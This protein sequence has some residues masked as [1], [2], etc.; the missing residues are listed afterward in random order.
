MAISSGS[1]AAR[2]SGT[3]SGLFPTDWTLSWANADAGGQAAKRQR[4]VVAR[5]LLTYASVLV[6]D[7][8]T[9][10]LD[11]TTASELVDEVLSATGGPNDA[12][13][14]SSNEGLNIVDRIVSL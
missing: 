10:H 14:H 5:T 3:G 4:I 8:P 1:F 12:A 13:D 7:E 6:L 11:P 2:A 9:A